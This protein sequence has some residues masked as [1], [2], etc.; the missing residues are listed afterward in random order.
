VTSVHLLM[1]VRSDDEDGESAKMIGV[2]SSES[3]AR[4]AIERVMSQPGFADHPDG[5]HID[6][7]EIDQDNWSGGFISWDEAYPPN[8]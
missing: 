4:A 2:Y 8:A 7:Y 3:A 1:H 6:E 5:F